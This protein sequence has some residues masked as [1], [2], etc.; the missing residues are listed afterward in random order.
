[1]AGDLAALVL[2]TDP[3]GDLRA[4][5]AR[6]IAAARPRL[7]PVPGPAGATRV[8]L[9]GYNGAC[10]T[11][12][13]LRTG[14][15]V[16]GL[17]AAFGAGRLE[18]GVVAMGPWPLPDWGEVAVERIEG[19]P[20]DAVRALCERYDAVAVCEGSLFTSTFSDA[21][22]ALLT[23][24]LGMA[25]ALGKPAVA[26]GAEA[27]RMSAPVEDFVR[28]HAAGALL[29]AR[30]APS[31]RRLAGLGLAASA[32][33]DT[34][35]SCRPPRPEAGGAALR[36]LG[37]DGAAEVLALCPADPFRWPVA[38]D[39]ARAMLA[40]VTGVP[41]PD[42][43]RGTSF[44]RPAAAAGPRLGLLLDEIARAVRRHGAGR[45]G[46]LFPVVVGMEPLDGPAC[47]GLAERLGAPAPLL[48]GE[49]EPGLIV[50]VL[51]A[52]ARAVSARYHAALL[53]LSAGVPAVGLAYDGR[54]PALMDE[55]GRGDLSLRVDAP[56]LAVLLAGR[57]DALAGDG[58]AA[59]RAFAG[60]A[61]G[62]RTAQ[63][64]MMRAAARHL[65]GVRR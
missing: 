64:G 36:A 15:I 50:A 51:G 23:A 32:G 60:F 39:P 55:A 7:G 62:R 16:R 27:D 33:T 65:A 40:Q 21:L 28:R 17:R 10:N 43:H 3:D 25:V 26:L 4:A 12:A 35:W 29:I 13:D 9:A 41:D 38:T 56:D 6:A 18:L 34:G 1:M 45:P 30:N 14:E 8:L 11:G 63:A 24:F 46:G 42:H 31:R 48:A 49:A 61:A 52:A 53:A 5:Y 2:S 22:A 44:F 19:F 47:S 54:I 59:G 20:P 57:L 37:W 58:G